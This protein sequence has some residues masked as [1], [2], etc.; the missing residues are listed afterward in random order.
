MIDVSA[1]DALVLPPASPGVHMALL[2][3]CGDVICPISLILPA[4]V[5]GPSPKLPTFMFVENLLSS[6]CKPLSRKCW[7]LFLADFAAPAGRGCWTRP[8][9]YFWPVFHSFAGGTGA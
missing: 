5:P 6:R 7:E 9:F 3:A 8:V 4:Y 1:P 2:A